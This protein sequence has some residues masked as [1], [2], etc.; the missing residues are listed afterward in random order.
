MMKQDV[1]DPALFDEYREG[2]RIEVNNR[3]GRSEG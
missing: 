2:N 3:C 1:S